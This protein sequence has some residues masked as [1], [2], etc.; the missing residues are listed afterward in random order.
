LRNVQRARAVNVAVLADRGRA[1]D[2]YARLARLGTF[3]RGGEKRDDIDG[4]VERYSNQAVLGPL[5]NARDFIAL[6][7]LDGHECA[8]LD[9][10]I[11]S[12]HHAAGRYVTDQAELAPVPHEQGS[13]PQ[14]A[15]EAILAPAIRLPRRRG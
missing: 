5:R 1:I 6:L 14:Q 12:D 13:N 11:R 10:R 7:Q 3:L 2:L 15:E 8:H 9:R 4:R